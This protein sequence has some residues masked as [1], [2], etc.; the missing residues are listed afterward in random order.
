MA[1]AHKSPKGKRRAKRGQDLSVEPNDETTTGKE[2]ALAGEG[3]WK[4]LAL[5]RIAW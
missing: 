5:K 4:C 2:K 1:R 3:A